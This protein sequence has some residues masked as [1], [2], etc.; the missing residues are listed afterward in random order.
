MCGSLTGLASLLSIEPDTLRIFEK[1]LTVT[2]EQYA[3]SR[4]IL[5]ELL[6][7]G[8]SPEHL[9]QVGL[10]TQGALVLFKDLRI[11]LPSNLLRPD[12]SDER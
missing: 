9:V 2:E 3:E 7:W 1:S 10:S 8:V 5:L 11:R 6:S 12:L 4:I